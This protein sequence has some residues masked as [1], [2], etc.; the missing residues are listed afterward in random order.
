[1][2]NTTEQSSDSKPEMSSFAAEGCQKFLPVIFKNTA[3][4]LIGRLL[5]FPL[6]VFLQ[7]SMDTYVIYSNRC[8]GT[9][10]EQTTDLN[11][12]CGNKNDSQ[13]SPSN[14][15]N[16]IYTISTPPDTLP[17]SNE[18]GSAHVHKSGYNVS[19]EELTTAIPTITAVSI[20]R[21][22]FKEDSNA[23]QISTDRPTR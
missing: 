19:N 23:S 9:E 1:M 12:V 15:S 2:Q 21:T 3:V 4:D 6:K 22:T 17:D 11:P 20:H 5:S 7:S 16:R 8:G 10:L 18:T 14:I 13:F